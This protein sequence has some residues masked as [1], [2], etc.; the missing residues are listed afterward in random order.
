MCCCGKCWVCCCLYVNDLDDNVMNIV[1]EFADYTKF[2]GFVDRGRVS[3]DK[4]EVLQFAI[5]TRTVLT[6]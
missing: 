2:G 3:L 5:Q 6:L 1:S 4:C